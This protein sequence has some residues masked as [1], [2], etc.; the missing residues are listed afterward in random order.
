LIG[1]LFGRELH[2]PATLIATVVLKTVLAPL[3][4]GS[5]LRRATPSLSA[6]LERPITHAASVVLGLGVVLILIR[7]WPAVVQVAAAPT[8]LAIALFVL[9]GLA[10]GH[11]LGGPAPED[12]T[13]LALST[14]TRHP[15]VAITVAGAIAAD[16]A[17]LAPVAATVV[18]CLL[19]A[20][21]VTAPYVKMRRRGSTSSDAP[22]GVAA[23]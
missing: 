22:A 20:A 4:V 15:G 1:R 18:L 7:M 11:L 12:R 2:V 5:L 21:I 9:A 8:L 19:V 23:G 10:V 3:L 14:S 17:A 13:V 16:R 6:R